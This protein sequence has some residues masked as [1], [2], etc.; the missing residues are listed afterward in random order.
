MNTSARKFSILTT[1]QRRGAATVRSLHA[2]RDD[3]PLIDACSSALSSVTETVGPAVVRVGPVGR[4]GSGSGV[5]ISS[6][7][8]VLTNSHDSVARTN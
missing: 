4:R 8:L 5:I 1:S 7:G 6:D 2:E 3:A